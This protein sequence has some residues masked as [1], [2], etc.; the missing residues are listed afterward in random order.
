MGA[1]VIIAFDTKFQLPKLHGSQCQLERLK[2]LLVFGWLLV[3]C[4]IRE[5]WSPADIM[6]SRLACASIN[7]LYQFYHGPLSN[8]LGSS[9]E[10]RG[11]DV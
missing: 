2:L 4:R 5:T 11:M 6:M 10:Y 7:L 8:Q 9:S 3:G 1:C